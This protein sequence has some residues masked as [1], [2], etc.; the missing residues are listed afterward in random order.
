MALTRHH[1]WVGVFSGEHVTLRA[2]ALEDGE[3]AGEVQLPGSSTQRGTLALAPLR[4]RLLAIKAEP[5]GTWIY[6]IR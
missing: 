1:A 4:H 2:L 5:S 3:V 6:T